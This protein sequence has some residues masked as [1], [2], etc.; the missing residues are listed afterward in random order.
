MKR[1]CFTL[2]FAAAILLPVS[3]RA[4]AVV[5]SLDV[6]ALKEAVPL[7]AEVLDYTS[8]GF[9]NAVYVYDDSLVLAVNMADG[10]KCRDILEIIDLRDT[11]ERQSFL[12]FGHEEGKFFYVQSFLRGDRL[13]V[14]DIV[15]KLLLVSDLRES[16]NPGFADPSSAVGVGYV[17][18]DMAEYSDRLVLVNPRYFEGGRGRSNRQPRLVFTDAAF[19]WDTPSAGYFSANVTQGFVVAEAGRDRILFFDANSSTIEVYSGKLASPLKV[20]RGPDLAMPSYRFMTAPD[21]T[22]TVYHE[23]KPESGYVRAVADSSRVIAAYR[24]GEEPQGDFLIL[25]DWDGNLLGAYRT[26]V[27]VETLSLS[28]D[29]K[30]LYVW[31]DSGKEDVPP[32]LLRYALP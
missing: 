12:G 1:H 24:Y 6:S 16:G 17:A 5:D 29:G 8:D 25:F 10:V 32:R 7:S 2:I 26:S 27:R 14:F 30:R 22:V 15:K 19:Q 9:E 3:C 11:S 28:R 31:E 23:T 21:G 13:I 18:Q 20:L 4:A